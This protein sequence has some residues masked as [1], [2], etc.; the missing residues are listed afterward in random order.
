MLMELEDKA[1]RHPLVNNSLIILILMDP[2][3]IS[4]KKPY[5]SHI[6]FITASLKK[7]NPHW[8]WHYIK[9]HHVYSFILEIHQYLIEE[10]ERIC[11]ELILNT[12]KKYILR[13]QGEGAILN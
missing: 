4:S 11:N 1:I 7:D 10:T 13:E 12:D 3:L 5:T 6:P 9:T 8:P 2:K